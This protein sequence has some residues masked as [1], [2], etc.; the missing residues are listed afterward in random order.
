VTAPLAIVKLLRLQQIAC[1]YIPEDGGDPFHDIPGGNP[2][3]DDFMSIHEDTPHQGI[4][5][6]RFRRD[7]DKICDALGPEAARYDGMVEPEQRFRNKEA[8]LAGDHKWFVATPDVGG[9]GITLLNGLTNVYYS[10]G[11]KLVQ[12][13]QSEDRSHRIGQRNPV[14]YIDQ[15]AEDTIDMHIVE[16]LVKKRDISS[17]V[18]GDEI[19]QWIKG[20]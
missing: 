19:F 4:V 3:L 14:L 12:R 2:R 20:A 1:G 5:W 13:L 17:Q 18:L 8:F 16:A 7:I 10:N 11:F 6:A 9:E 15:I